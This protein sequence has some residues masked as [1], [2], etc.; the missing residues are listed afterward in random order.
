MTRFS[1]LVAVVICWPALSIAS[2]SPAGEISATQLR[3]LD[4]NVYPSDDDRVKDRERRLARDSRGRLAAARVR[5]NRAW[6]PVKGR[7]SWERFRDVRLHALR[8]S[9]GQFPTPPAYLRVRVTRTLEGDGYCIENLVYET[10]P[11]L[12]ATANL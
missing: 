7:A 4:G 11:G 3:S 8:A 5:E 9:L 10:R 2:E 6:R 1:L 12:V